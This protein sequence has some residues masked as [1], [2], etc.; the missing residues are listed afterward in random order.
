MAGGGGENEIEP[1]GEIDNGSDSL[2][3]PTNRGSVHLLPGLGIADTQATPWNEGEIRR[4]HPPFD[5]APIVWL[6]IAH[7]HSASPHVNDSNSPCRSEPS[8]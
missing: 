4:I 6:S 1:S 7:A 5:V 3:N 2:P 8:E